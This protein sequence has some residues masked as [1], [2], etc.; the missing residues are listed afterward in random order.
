MVTGAVSDAAQAIAA[1]AFRIGAIETADGQF[2]QIRDRRERADGHER[3]GGSLPR[4]ALDA[5]GHEQ[6]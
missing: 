2:H 1:A 6:T 5:V 3:D 4:R